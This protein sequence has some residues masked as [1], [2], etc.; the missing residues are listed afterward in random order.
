MPRRLI[1]SIS[2]LFALVA[3]PATTLA[4]GPVRET[5]VF[6]FTEPS[7]FGECDGFDMVATRAYIQRE[8]LTW[9]DADENPLR[10]SRHVYF[11]F[12]LVN[13]VSGT[14]ARYIGRFHRAA[15][16][17]TGEEALVGAFRQL[18]IDNR[19]VWSA[20]G[21]NGFV[22]EDLVVTN[23]NRSLFEWEAGLCDAMA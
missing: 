15:D 6:D 11:D 13:S 7:V 19:N 14:E 18:Y 2:V 17:V 23:G 22:G 9:Y 20:S 10:E 4:A 12:T 5:A 3:L 21:L 8:T 16:F 1:L